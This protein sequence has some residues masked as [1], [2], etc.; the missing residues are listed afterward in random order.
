M[1]TK[2]GK[3]KIGEDVGMQGKGEIGVGGEDDGGES[4]RTRRGVRGREERGW[5]DG[6]GGLEEMEVVV[7]RS[8]GGGGSG[9]LRRQQQR[10]EAAAMAA[11]A[12]RLHDENQRT[13]QGEAADTA[14]G[15]AAARGGAAAGTAAARGGAAAVAAVGLPPCSSLSSHLR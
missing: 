14:A 10:P 13:R 8:G 6:N 1:E 3:A 9:G 12:G 7:R 2:G 4:D 15:T 5:N 11:A